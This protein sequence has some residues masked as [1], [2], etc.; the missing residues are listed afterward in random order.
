VEHGVVLPLGLRSDVC[1]R[2]GYRRGIKWLLGRRNLLLVGLFPHAFLLLF[3][4][5]L[6]I[7]LPS[8]ALLPLSPSRLQA[9]LGKLVSM[10]GNV[11]RE[12]TQHAA[13]TYRNA[14]RWKGGGGK[15][16]KLL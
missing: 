15:I 1:R 8:L 4:L 12:T 6:R 13:V 11:Q 10:D 9:E 3:R 5:C 14:L 2:G 16:K 7:N